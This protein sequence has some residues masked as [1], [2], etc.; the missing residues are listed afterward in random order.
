MQLCICFGWSHPACAQQVVARFNDPASSV[1]VFLLSMR[2]GGVGLNLQVHVNESFSRRQHKCMYMRM[3]L[4]QELITALKCV[5]A[6]RRHS[7][8][9]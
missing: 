4:S 7:N 8:N 9:V 1:A 5:T 2:A 6:G 3:Q